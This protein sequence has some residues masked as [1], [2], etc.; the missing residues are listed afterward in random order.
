MT[1]DT[2]A[3]ISS[4]ARETPTAGVDSSSR[5]TISMRRPSTPPSSLIMAAIDW[6]AWVTCW[7]C[8]P[9]PPDSGKITPT[10]TVPCAA[11][12]S[13]KPS[14]QVATRVRISFMQCLLVVLRS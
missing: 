5:L 7:P 3:P 10:L 6:M 12:A 11:A 13:E 9:A 1:T 4:L 2:P 8:G 14:A